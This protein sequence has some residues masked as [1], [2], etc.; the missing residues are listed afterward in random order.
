M[1][2]RPYSH[3]GIIVI[4]AHDSK[5]LER[6]HKVLEKLLETETEFD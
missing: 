2:A 4:R 5:S 6:C 3:S 1:S